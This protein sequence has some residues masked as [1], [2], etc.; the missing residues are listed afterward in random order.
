M[1]R[2]RDGGPK[3]PYAA[4]WRMHLYK[5]KPMDVEV[6]D[7]DSES[8]HINTQEITGE[9]ICQVPLSN[10]Q[11]EEIESS[12][13]DISTKGEVS[14]TCSAIVLLLES[15]NCLADSNLYGSIKY[16]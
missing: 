5:P 4:N 10:T 13:E 1:L 15:R 12:T 7:T 2:K 9:D 11:V 16:S 6:S 8:S 14:S 3:V